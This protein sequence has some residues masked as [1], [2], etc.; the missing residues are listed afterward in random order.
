VTSTTVEPADVGRACP[1]CRFPLKGN[2]EAERCDACGALH[3]ADCWQDGGGCAVHGCAQ[4]TTTAATPAPATAKVAPALP[5]APPAPPSPTTDYAPPSGPAPSG[6]PTS[7]RGLL[8][9]LAAGLAVAVAAVAGFAL[10]SGGGKDDASTAAD[11]TVQTVTTTTTT[12]DPV[13]SPSAPIET[14]DDREDRLARRIAAIVSYSQAG[15]SAV[16]SGRYADAVANRETVLRRLRALSGVTGRLASARATLERAM[17]ASLE[18]DESYAAGA[19]ATGS[20]AEATRLKAVF[21]RQ[22]APIA[23][24][25]ELSRYGEGDF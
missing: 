14:A 19:D 2:T 23:N 13:T 7:R 8:I 17:E 16:R 5:P 25:H 24:A 12:A 20:D 18:S 1:Y 6:P 11:T 21:T 9:G 22:W 15:R 10:A 3:H 4:A